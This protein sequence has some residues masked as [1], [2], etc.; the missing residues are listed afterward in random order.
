MTSKINDNGLD[1]VTQQIFEKI[2]IAQK[3]INSFVNYSQEDKDYNIEHNHFK[4]SLIDP[5]TVNYIHYI[6]NYIKIIQFQ[7]KNIFF[8]INIYTKNY[9]NVS[10]YIYLIKLAII[11]CLYDKTEF[12]E[13]ITLR[14]DMYLTDLKKLLPDIPGTK[15]KKQ[16]AKSGY[17]IF[18]DNMYI[19]IYRKEE[20]F[21]SLVQE[22]F[23]AFTLDLD[24]DKINY[25]NILSNNFNIENDFLINNS[26]IEFCS[27]LIN[28]GI[29]LYF[30]KNIKEL[31]L[32]KK[33][34]R[35]H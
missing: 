14:I 28:L 27:R 12:Y 19:C 7:Y 35:R 31:P 20:W 26:I 3:N 5:T 15:L 10:N 16:H 24:G 34:S 22:L 30:E 29:F 4:N 11:C 18:N 6:T 1:L 32:F 8:N 25:K 23:F 13:K 17:S 33:I 9:E 2:V 21:K